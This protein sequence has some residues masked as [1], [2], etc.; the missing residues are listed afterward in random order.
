M[1]DYHKQLVSVLKGILP[2]Y[3]ELKLHKGLKTPCISYQELNNYDDITGDTRGYSRISYRI[4]VW[5][6]D[7]EDLQNYSR[8]I[9]AELRSLGWKRTGANELHDTNSTMVQ[10]ILTYEATALE[11]Y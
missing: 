1:I 2:T 7:I 6:N 3:Y 10:K 9:D 5:G 4:K 11:D 8:I